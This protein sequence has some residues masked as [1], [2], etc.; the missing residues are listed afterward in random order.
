MP[1]SSLKGTPNRTTLKAAL[2]PGTNW[3]L[4]ELVLQKR[5]QPLPEWVVALTPIDAILYAM[6]LAFAAKYYMIATDLA[7]KV[8][9]YYHPRLMAAQVKHEG[10]LTLEQLVLESM[11]PTLEKAR[12]DAELTDPTSPTLIEHVAED[13]KDITPDSE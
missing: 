9:P 13:I 1:A 12:R 3:V 10:T 5:A 4:P 8:A 2:L 6:R 11:Q 7:A